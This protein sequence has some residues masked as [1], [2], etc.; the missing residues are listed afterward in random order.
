MVRRSPDV[1]S[2]GVGDEHLRLLADWRGQQRLHGGSDPVDDGPQ[3]GRLLGRGLAEFLDGGR[4]RAALRMPKHH[5][6]PRAE[7]CGR[8]FY[9]ADLRRRHDISRDSDHEQVA[10]TLPKDKFGG[11]AGVGTSEHNGE[12]L[13]SLSESQATG[14][15]EEGSRVCHARDKPLIALSQSPERFMS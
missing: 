6:Q 8:K 3:T 13:L 14:R 15:S 10:K 1:R 4:D 11:Y 7:A 12:G 2:D 5:D 9:A